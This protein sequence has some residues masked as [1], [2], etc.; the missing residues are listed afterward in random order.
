[1]DGRRMFPRFGTLVLIASQVFLARS[2]AQSSTCPDDMSSQQKPEIRV[3]V[4]AV[5]FHG[6][7]SL[8]QPER[9]ALAEDITKTHFVTSSVT[10]DDWATEA[11]DLPLSGAM[12]ATGYL[13]C[14][15]HR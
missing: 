3:I 15:A 12:H 5:E 8:S 6:E 9:T 2:P 13:K 4:D 10:H 11:A 1:M 14:L 7:N